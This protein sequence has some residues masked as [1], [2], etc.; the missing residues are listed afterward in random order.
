[1]Q[2]SKHVYQYESRR[3]VHAGGTRN[4]RRENCDGANRLE[5]A[6][7]TGPESRMGCRQ[8]H[9]GTSWESQ[10]ARHKTVLR[11]SDPHV[12]YSMAWLRPQAPDL[13]PTEPSALDGSAEDVTF[14]Q[15]LTLR[16]MAGVWLGEV[17]SLRGVGRWGC[18]CSQPHRGTHTVTSPATL[19][20]A[21]PGRALCAPHIP[22]LCMH[23]SYL[24][25]TCLRLR[26]PCGWQ[27]GCI[28][29][30]LPCK[31]LALPC[32]PWPS[33]GQNLIATLTAITGTDSPTTRL[34]DGR[35]RSGRG[36]SGRGS[37]CSVP[38][39]PHPQACVP[40]HHIGVGVTYSPRLFTLASSTAAHTDELH[41]VYAKILPNAYSM[42]HAS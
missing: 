34:Q 20:F 9:A 27:G 36:R 13:T 16:G 12:P 37:G 15:P 1:M 26:L 10:P 6:R 24:F 4:S 31:P 5:A 17:R 33:P 35:G 19:S 2:S 23:A 21:S 28:C 3:A 41:T 38:A 30:G 7:Q 22:F 29:Q 8:V 40:I 11:N 18:R 14:M 32:S 39:T 42:S 25:R